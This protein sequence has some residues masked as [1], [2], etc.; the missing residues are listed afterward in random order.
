MTTDRFNKYWAPIIFI[1]VAIIAGGSRVIWSKY[2]QS[3]IIEISLATSPELAGQGQIV[4]NP[5]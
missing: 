4:Y 5:I 3:Q 2:S 1:L